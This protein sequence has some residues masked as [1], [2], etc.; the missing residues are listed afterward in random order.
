MVDE[1][2]MIFFDAF[3]SHDSHMDDGL[4]PA[5]IPRLTRSQS[6]KKIKLANTS[7]NLA[8][9]GA[10]RGRFLQVSRSEGQ[11]EQSDGKGSNPIP[12]IHTST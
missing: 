5:A 3:H 7:F 4:A 6:I 1:D 9:R 11:L 2:D 8:F 10:F 12:H